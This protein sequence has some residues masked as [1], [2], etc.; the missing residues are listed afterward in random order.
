MSPWFWCFPTK[1]KSKTNNNVTSQLT[2]WI[3]VHHTIDNVPFTVNSIFI[4]L[5]FHCPN[6]A[7]F[8]F[9][10]CAL[11]P[12]S[13]IFSILRTGGSY[14]CFHFS[15]IFFLDLSCTMGN[16]SENKLTTVQV[17]HSLCICIVV[18][19]GKMECDLSTR[20]LL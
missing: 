12:F 10:D 9:C 14:W 15:N 2:E 19:M 5:F 7:N 8:F 6:L 16:Q 11:Q 20:F 13:S 1:K 17:K 3:R 4:D 18:G